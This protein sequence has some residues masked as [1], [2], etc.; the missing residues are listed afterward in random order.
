MRCTAENPVSLCGNFRIGNVNGLVVF[1][2]SESY[3]VIYVRISCRAKN[4]VYFYSDRANNKPPRHT[5]GKMNRSSLC[6]FKIDRFKNGIA[7]GGGVNN[8]RTGGG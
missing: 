5:A 1:R 3:R 4:I 8:C 2:S 6:V 7:T